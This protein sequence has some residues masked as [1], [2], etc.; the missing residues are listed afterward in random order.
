[1]ATYQVLYWKNIPTQVKVYGNDRVVSR[2]LSKRFQR[3]IDRVAMAEDLIAGDAYLDQFGWGERKKSE[4][5]PEE[6]I[7]VIIA[8]LERQFDLLASE[9]LEATNESSAERS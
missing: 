1:M 6:V 5:S 4:G 2:E 3:L 8:E 9:H 7:E